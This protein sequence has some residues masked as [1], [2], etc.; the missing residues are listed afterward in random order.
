MAT[1]QIKT[2]GMHCPSCSMLIE[3]D[4]TD[5]PGVESVKASVADGT[6]DV[7]YDPTKIDAETIADTIRKLGYGADVVA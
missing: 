3:M 6:T 1:T 4:V 5:L 2:T 7:T